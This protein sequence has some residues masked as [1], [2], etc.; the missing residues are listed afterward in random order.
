V[1]HVCELV[2]PMP[3]VKQSTA[4]SKRARI[5]SRVSII[6]IML[7]FGVAETN[8]TLLLLKRQ[9]LLLGSSL[10]L[11]LLPVFIALPLAAAFNMYRRLDQCSTEQS[12]LP[13]LQ[14]S[15]F[16]L[17]LIVYAVLTSLMAMLT[18]SLELAVHK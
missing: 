1:Q 18:N 15:F 11:Y 8:G 3:V 10:F 2:E 6:L 13:A 7:L 4:T 5:I 9:E 17:V 16:T 12:S 14:N